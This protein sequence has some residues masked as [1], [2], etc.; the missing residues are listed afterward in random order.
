MSKEHRDSFIFYNSFKEAIDEV[1]DDQQLSIYQSIA[2]YA[3]YREEPNLVGVAKIV[4]VLIK[5]QLDANWR[6]YEKGCRGGAPTGVSNNPN[7]RRGKNKPE[8]NQELTRNKPNDNDNVNVNDN[9]NIN[10]KENVEDLDIN[11]IPILSDIIYF[12]NEAKLDVDAEQFYD[13]YSSK[14]W[15]LGDLPMAD[16]RAA[17]RNWS[18][19]ASKH[20]TTNPQTHISND[21]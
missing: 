14:G 1:A 8:T 13:Y 6:K 17:L 21:L 18:R 19:Y 9:V 5:P 11:N 7:G 15:I 12:I 2:N 16:W 20:T 3:L 10:I 4:W